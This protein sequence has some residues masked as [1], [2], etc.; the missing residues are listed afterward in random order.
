MGP[1]QKDKSLMLRTGNLSGCRARGQAK[2]RSPG[3]GHAVPRRRRRCVW[4]QVAR[5]SVPMAPKGL[6]ASAGFAIFFSSDHT[7]CARFALPPPRMASEKELAD[8][9]TSIE[10]RAI[11]QTV[12][13]VRDDDAALDIVQ[14]AM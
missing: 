5:P 6:L 13:A 2:N 8:F 12:Y 11:K 9:L 14:D 10:R 7:A 4:G 1:P 3:T